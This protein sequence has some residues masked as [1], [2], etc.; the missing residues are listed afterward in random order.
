MSGLFQRPFSWSI[1]GPVSLQCNLYVAN[2]LKSRSKVYFLRKQVP[3]FKHNILSPTLFCIDACL[4]FQCFF[5]LHTL[6]TLESHSFHTLFP[7]QAMYFPTSVPSPLCFSPVECSS[8]VSY[9]LFKSIFEKV[10]LECPHLREKFSVPRTLTELHA[11]FCYS[12]CWILSD[13]SNFKYLTVRPYVLIFEWEN[14]VTTRIAF[15]TTIH[16][17]FDGMEGTVSHSSSYSQPLSLCLQSR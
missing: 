9:V 13:S 3:T 7:K 1:Y 10:S 15:N 6:H 2:L 4:S 16:K 8:P 12:Q 11:F 14:I 5:P 17:L